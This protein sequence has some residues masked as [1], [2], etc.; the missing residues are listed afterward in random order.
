MEMNGLMHAG[1]HFPFHKDATTWREQATEVFLQEIAIQ[2]HPDGHQ[3]ELSASYHG[4]CFHNYM[5]AVQALHQGGYTVDPRLE[6]CLQDQ[7]KPLRA[8]AHHDQR[9]KCFDFQ[10]SQQAYVGNYLK[11]CPESW[12]IEG[13]QWFIDGSGPTPSTLH[14]YLPNA[15][16]A[17]MRSGYGPDA[18]SVA[19][20]G[21]PYGDGHQHEDKLGIQIYARGKD[22][23]GEAG[24]VDYHDTPER[25]Y[26]LTTLGHSTAIVDGMGQNRGKTYWDNRDAITGDRRYAT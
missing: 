16:Y 3:V 7:L 9:G 25:R 23:I 14:H 10:D 15:G 22:I 17:I 6:Q 24:K 8:L 20:D 18:L 11:R 19:F 2:F 26:S 21:G 4:V 1:V 13:D 12:L 5:R